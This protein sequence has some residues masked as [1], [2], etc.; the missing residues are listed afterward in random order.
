[1]AG[2]ESEKKFGLVFGSRHCCKIKN[3]VKIAAQILER[4]KP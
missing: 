1:M 2:S 3:V 4:E